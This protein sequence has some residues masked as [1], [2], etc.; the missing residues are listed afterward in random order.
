MF[1]RERETLQRLVLVPYRP[2][3]NLSLGIGG[4]I[5]IVAAGLGGFYAGTRYGSNSVG[6]SP[7]EVERLRQT[8][9]MYAERSRTMR[10]QAAVAQH[11]REIVLE[12]TEQ[13]RLENKKLLENMTVLE[14]QVATYKRLLSPRAAA[15]AGLSADRLDLHATTSPGRVSYRLLLTQASRSAGS[16]AGMLEARLVGGGRSVVVPVGDNRFELQY[17]QS[18]TGEWQLPSG[19]RPERVDIVLTPGRGAPVQKSF[20][21]EVQP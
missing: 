16:I 9:R 8:V 20:R 10:D 6:A 12:A 2:F 19:F 13:L 14:D 1:R 4:V 17:F 18:L 3:R 11:D 21:W 5:L 7:E 15:S